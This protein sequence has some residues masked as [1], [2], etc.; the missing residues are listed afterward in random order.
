MNINNPTTFSTPNL[1][2]STSNSSGT[3][4]A[5]RADDTILVYDATVPTTIAYGA[6]A[7]AGDTATAAHRNHN[8]GM[9]AAAIS[10]VTGT[11]VGDGE[12]S[13]AIAAGM[14]G[15]QVKFCMVQARVTSTGDLINRG[16]IYTSDTI[17]DDIAAGCSL[18]LWNTATPEW[19]S[20]GIIALGSNSFTVDDAGGNAHPNQDGY[21]YN[22]IAWGNG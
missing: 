13:N 2:L 14:T 17:V 22:F 11:Y 21:T 15:T 18:N 3:A 10:C 19:G 6:S 4:G 8:H 1:T 9:A 20:N 5:L 12:T 7:A 16:L